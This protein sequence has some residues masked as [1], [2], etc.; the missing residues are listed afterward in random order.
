[1]S[2]TIRRVR[3]L[4]AGLV[5]SVCLG[6]FA[7][8]VSAFDCYVESQCQGGGYVYCYCYGGTT[9]GCETFPGGCRYDCDGQSGAIIC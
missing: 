9:G 2:V 8:P 7:L 6:G 3:N 1:M 5:L 4:V